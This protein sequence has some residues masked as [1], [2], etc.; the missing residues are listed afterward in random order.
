IA[1]SAGNLPAVESLIS[2]GAD[3]DG[4][5]KTLRTP[6]TLAIVTGVKGALVKE[7]YAQIISLLASAGAR[8]DITANETCNPLMTSALL[9][10]ELAVRYFLSLGA[11]PDVKCRPTAIARLPLVAGVGLWLLYDPLVFFSIDLTV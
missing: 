3:L 8:L 1:V 11:N 10:S 4:I 6:L 2:A 7:E 5:D 9:K